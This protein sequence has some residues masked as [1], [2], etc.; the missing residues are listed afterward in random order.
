KAVTT[1]CPPS[2]FLGH[3]GDDDF[4]F[5]CPPDQA[6]PLT[7]R[8]VTDF[9]HDANRLY[10]PGDA[11]RGY[12]EVPDRRGNK[13]KAALVTLS[14]GVAQATVERPKLNG[15]PGRTSQ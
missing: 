5:I 3:I 15:T 13:N 8:T 2:I 4:V 1:I 12:I 11:E 6:L 7:K 10:D 14:I 9:E